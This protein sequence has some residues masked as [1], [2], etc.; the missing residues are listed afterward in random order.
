MKRQQQIVPKLRKKKGSQ[1]IGREPVIPGFDCT[2][3]VP[4]RSSQCE[5]NSCR[6]PQ[7]REELSGDRINSMSR[8][9]QPPATVLH[10]DHDLLR[11]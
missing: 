8:L 10:S 6:Q 9:S 4:Y 7:M 1:E 3:A 2:A 11:F 5:K